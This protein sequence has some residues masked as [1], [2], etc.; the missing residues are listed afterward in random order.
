MEGRSR[1]LIKPN[2]C[3]E[4]LRKIMNKSDKIVDASA[5]IRNGHQLVVYLIKKPRRQEG[6]FRK[7]D[8][9]SLNGMLDEFRKIY[10]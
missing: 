1:G 6:K 9:V 3:L 5:G 8:L 7:L 4:G 2:I 10:N